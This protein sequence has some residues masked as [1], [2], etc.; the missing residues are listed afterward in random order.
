[1]AMAPSR[2]DSAL[3]EAERS[4]DIRLRG[5]TLAQQRHG[6]WVERAQEIERVYGEWMEALDNLMDSAPDYV[7]LRRGDPISYSDLRAFLSS[8]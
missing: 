5:L 3:Y 1:M 6:D 7:A 8:L 2:I 4:L